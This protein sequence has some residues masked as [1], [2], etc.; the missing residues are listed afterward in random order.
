MKKKPAF[1]STARPY[2]VF[3]DVLTVQGGH[4]NP[5]IGAGQVVD[6]GLTDYR[7]EALTGGAARERL[8]LVAGALP[9]RHPVWLAGITALA[10]LCWILFPGMPWLAAVGSVP[11][12]LVLI[13]HLLI[14]QYLG[15][16]TPAILRARASSEE[17]A[18]IA[19]VSVNDKSWM[20][21]RRIHF[22][23][24]T[25]QARHGTRHDAA[26]L[27][28]VKAVLVRD[29]PKEVMPEP[30]PGPDSLFAPAPSIFDQI[31]A[32]ITAKTAAEQIAELE[33]QATAARP[34]P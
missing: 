20:D 29:R 8:L 31:V 1:R 21:L 18:T 12:E 13:C 33:S 19:A 7:A 32:V 15:R 9:L 10:I 28:A 27:A 34:I 17:D 23:L 11:L 3:L 2:R 14:C 30:M 6:R 22:A 5:K 4:W 25:L 16:R 26:A 24:R